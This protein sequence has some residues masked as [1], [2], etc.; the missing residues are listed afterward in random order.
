MP[1]N[2]QIPDDINTLLNQIQLNERLK[3]EMRA[4]QAIRSREVD[5]SVDNPDA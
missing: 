4:E 5:V 3:D 1:N 2:K